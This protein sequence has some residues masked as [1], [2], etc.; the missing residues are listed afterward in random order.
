M[1]NKLHN[2]SQ[3]KQVSPAG[4]KQ[5]KCLLCEHNISQILRQKSRIFHQWQSPKHRN[6]LQWQ[7]HSM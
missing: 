3:Y 6:Q 1:K 2:L 5:T 4:K 7:I